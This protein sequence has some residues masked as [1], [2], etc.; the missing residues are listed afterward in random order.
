MDN[1]QDYDARRR[2]RRTKRMLQRLL[3]LFIA[4]LVILGLA[5][6]ITSVIQRASKAEGSG[7]PGGPSSVPAVSSPVLSAPVSGA[8]GENSSWNFVGPVEQTISEMDLISPDYRMIAL[9]ENGRVDMSY[10][11]TVTFVGDSITQGLQIY[12]T[13]GIPNAHYCAYKGVGPKQIYDGTQQTRY[14]GEKEIP[15]DALMASKPDNIYILLGTNAMVSMD[16]EALLAYY[17]EMLNQIKKFKDPAVG[18]YMQSITPV[19]AGTE[20]LDMVRIHGLNN[21]LAK[22]A[23]QQE[24]H[25]IDLN[26]ALAGDDGYLRPDFGASRDGYHLSPAGYSAWVDYLITHTAYDPRNPYI[27][28]GASYAQ[29]PVPEPEPEPAPVEPAPVEPPAA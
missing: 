5:W 13:N 26:E 11:D 6:V 3:V 21:A 24:V 8:A 29:V 25:F 1:F 2:K 22:L 10:F 27:T 18:I 19:L 16:D 9:P 12:K 23:R 7:E 17:D 4:V 15:M 14:D 20:R 28:D